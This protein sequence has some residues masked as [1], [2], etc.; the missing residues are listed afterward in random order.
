MTFLPLLVWSLLA[1]HQASAAN[2]TSPELARVV[3][4]EKRGADLADRILIENSTKSILKQAGENPKNIGSPVI[5]RD[6]NRWLVF[7][8]KPGSFNK[9]FTVYKVV[10]CDVKDIKSGRVLESI[11]LPSDV[12]ELANYLASWKKQFGELS[13]VMYMIPMLEPTGGFSLY[14]MPRQDN[15]DEII[16]GKDLKSS[17][18]PGEAKPYVVTTFHQTIH[19]VHPKDLIKSLPPGAHDPG[20]GHNHANSDYPTETD[21]AVAILFPNVRWHVLGK[22]V[23]YRIEPTGQ[24]TLLPM[25]TQDAK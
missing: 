16:I 18:L 7:Y 9:E 1:T 6:G 3:W 5:V 13:Y 25:P 21:V 23:H 10:E 2:A 20:F 22:G 17:Y 8:E 19:K 4:L 24:I 12:I 14:V 11:K 15:P